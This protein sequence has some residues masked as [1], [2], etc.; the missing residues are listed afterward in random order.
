[1]P[2]L[3]SIALARA[4]ADS[5]KQK[6]KSRPATKVS[7]FNYQSFFYNFVGVSRCLSPQWK[8]GKKHNFLSHLND[9]QVLMTTLSANDN[10]NGNNSS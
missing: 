2:I 9:V 10:E 1:M 4:G 3:A 5:I 8:A 7:F 6:Q